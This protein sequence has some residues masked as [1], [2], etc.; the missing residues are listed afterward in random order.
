MNNRGHS[1]ISGNH[2]AILH[3]ASN[4]MKIRP[5]ADDRPNEIKTFAERRDTGVPAR[6]GPPR[7]ALPGDA[8]LRKQVGRNYVFIRGRG[9]VGLRDVIRRRIRGSAPIR[10]ARSSRA[11]ARFGRPG[12]TEQSAPGAYVCRRLDGRVI[13]GS[14]QTRASDESPFFPAAAVARGITLYSITGRLLRIIRPDFPG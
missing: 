4:V 9:D 5:G 14:P 8:E 11:P 10:F 2:G 6:G 7:P 1:R 3:N 13:K 12:K